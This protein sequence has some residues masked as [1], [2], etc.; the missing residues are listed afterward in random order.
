MDNLI[1]VECAKLIDDWKQKAFAYDGLIYMMLKEEP[2][3]VVP[4]YIGKAETL[5]KTN[6]NLSVNIKSI[7]TDTQKFARWGDNYDYHI[8]DLSAAVLP[9]HDP[10]KIA[11]KYSSWAESLFKEHPTDTPVLK[12]KVFFWAKAWSAKNDTGPE[13]GLGGPTK[14]TFLEYLLIGL[15]SSAFGDVLLNREGRNRV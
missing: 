7:K 15:A 14:L 2:E 10:E 13:V 6:G 8:G 9:R 5:G 1:R 3:G 11:P 12:Q 4:L